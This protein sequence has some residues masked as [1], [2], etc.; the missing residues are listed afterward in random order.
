MM[1]KMS[2]FAGLAVG[3]FLLSIYSIVFAAS[4]AYVVPDGPYDID[5]NGDGVKDRSFKIYVPSEHDGSVAVPLMVDVHALGGN[6]YK[7]ANNTR[8]DLLAEAEPEARNQFVTV[9]P[10]GTEYPKS[11]NGGDGFSDE[12]LDYN[13]CC[14]EAQQVTG[15]NDVAFIEALVKYMKAK[16]VID[17][18]KINIDSDRIYGSGFSNGSALVQKVV[19]TKPE[20]FTAVYVSS[21]FLLQPIESD[22]QLSV[23][24]MLSHGK[25]DDPA[26][27]G[28][29]EKCYSNGYCTQ[30]P[31]AQYNFERWARLN[32]CEG[33]PHIDYEKGNSNCQVYDGQNNNC[34]GGVEVRLCSIDGEHNHYNTKYSNKNNDDV[35]IVPMGWDFVKD[36]R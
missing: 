27:Y 9:Y 18:V 17:G 3:L 5:I 16:P 22:H 25:G 7:Q 33:N 32:G 26:P 13:G 23:P 31:S 34:N 30:F 24:I 29:E 14:G 2:T 10:I 19:F 6:A 28:G 4:P 20:V 8:Y 12:N 36:Y 1:K 35:P 11:F 15:V 21:Q